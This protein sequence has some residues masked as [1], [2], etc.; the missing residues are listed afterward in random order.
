MISQQQLGVLHNSS[1]LYIAAHPMNTDKSDS[2]INDNLSCND[3]INTS[4]NEVM[5]SPVYLSINSIIQNLPIK[6]FWNFMEW[7]DTIPGPSSWLTAN[8]GQ[9][10]LRGQKVLFVT[11][12]VQNCHRESR[13]ELKD[14]LFNSLNISK[15]EYGY[16]TDSFKNQ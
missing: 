8:Q 7:M 9:G 15:Y 3:W 14:S 11:N 1:T 16:R 6:S 10:Y 2:V 13:Q 5:L 12:S 4:N